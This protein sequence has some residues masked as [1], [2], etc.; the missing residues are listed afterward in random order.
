ML[1]YEDSSRESREEVLE[2]G[3]KFPLFLREVGC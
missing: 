2:A 1:K 3:L